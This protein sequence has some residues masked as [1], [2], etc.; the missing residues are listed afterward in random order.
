M[1]PEMYSTLLEICRKRSCARAGCEVSRNPLAQPASPTAR[2]VSVLLTT[3]SALRARA[4]LRASWRLA[5]IERAS[6]LIGA[7]AV[8]SFAA[9]IAAEITA[10]IESTTSVSIS[11]KPADAETSRLLIGQIV[12]RQDGAHHLEDQSTNKP[13]DPD[14]KE[15]GEKS[16]ELLDPTLNLAFQVGSDTDEHLCELSG[17]L[18]HGDIGVSSLEE[19]T[20]TL[21]ALD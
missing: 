21:R 8:L 19:S 7:A 11:E 18:A 16:D 5:A 17:L 3:I 14:G 10:M 13:A 12:D 4:R 9:R 15:R 20:P 1:L 6:A 2:G